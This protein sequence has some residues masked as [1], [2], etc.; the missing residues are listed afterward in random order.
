MPFEYEWQ[1]TLQVQETPAADNMI[2]AL[3]TL[4]VYT[5]QLRRCTSCL[6][7]YDDHQMRYRKW[8]CQSSTCSETAQNCSYWLKV[9]SRFRSDTHY[10]F[11]HGYHS[12]MLSSPRQRPLTRAMKAEIRT[13]VSSSMK[14]A[15]IRNRLIDLFNL[16][17]TT[18]PELKTIQKFV[19]NYKNSVL[20]HNDVVADVVGLALDSRYSDDM[21]AS[22]AFSFGYSLD[23]DGNPVLGEGTEADPFVLAF[24]TKLLLKNLDRDPDTFVFH[25]D[26][27]F[28]LTKRKFPLFVCGVSDKARSF[29][30]VAFFIVSQRT[31]AQYSAALAAVSEQYLRV[32]GRPMRIK[33]FMADVEDAQFNGFTNDISSVMKASYLMCFF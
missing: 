31:E 9:I 6:D 29:H 22:V 30:P 13:M 21:D 8:F 24:S 4:K 12:S 26:A 25:M 7:N 17:A 15:R 32:V 1:A 27:T 16:T 5:N 18:V 28:K 10:F 33:T 11:E 14:P 2:D 19:Y 23:E 3:R 20:F